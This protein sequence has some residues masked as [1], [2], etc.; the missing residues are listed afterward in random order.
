MGLS[1]KPCHV[2]VLRV[3]VEDIEWPTPTSLHLYSTFLSTQST[4]HCEGDLPICHKCSIHLDDATAAI[5]RQNSHH[6]PAYW[7]RGDRVMKP[8]SRYRDG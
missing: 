6:T 7:C 4:L 2:P 3:M 8:I 1:T 5:V